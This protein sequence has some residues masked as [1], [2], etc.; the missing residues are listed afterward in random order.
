MR[1]RPAAGRRL[2]T[3]IQNDLKREQRFLPILMNFGLNSLLCDGRTFSRSETVYPGNFETVTD[4]DVGCDSLRGFVE[5]A[6][7]SCEVGRNFRNISLDLT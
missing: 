5:K 4:S 2:P 7:T 3:L 1:I 6:S